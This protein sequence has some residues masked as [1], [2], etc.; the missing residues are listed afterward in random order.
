MA[1]GS[2]S[3]HARSLRLQAAAKKTGNILRIMRKRGL[4]CGRQGYRAQA[5]KMGKK[6]GRK[7]N[8]RGAL[9]FG[10]LLAA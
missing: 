10:L 3:K 8:R 7:M 6:M 4:R 5:R 2:V 1:S 9:L